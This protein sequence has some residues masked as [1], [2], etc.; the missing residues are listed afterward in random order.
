M[1]ALFYRVLGARARPSGRL[2]ALLSG[3]LPL[4][5]RAGPG[6]RL[7]LLGVQQS[8]FDRLLPAILSDDV[9]LDIAPLDGVHRV[10]V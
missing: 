4:L 2:R 1:R 10:D 8:L 9:S 5:Q 6:R 7:L 3:R